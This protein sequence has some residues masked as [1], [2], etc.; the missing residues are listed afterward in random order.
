MVT[1][2]DKIDLNRNKLKKAFENLEFFSTNIKTHSELSIEL[3]EQIESL[4]KN[5]LEC[6]L[7]FET[8]DEKVSNSLLKLFLTNQIYVKG[9]P[10]ETTKK[11]MPVV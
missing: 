10:K 4:V 7:E 5:A 11:I 9:K 2:L 3:V 8:D 1:W 6:H